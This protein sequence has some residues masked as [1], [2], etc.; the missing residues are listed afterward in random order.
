GIRDFH[1]TGVQTC[2][3]PICGGARAA[4]RVRAAAAVVA[5]FAGNAHHARALHPG[6]QRGAGTAGRAYRAFLRGRRFLVGATVQHHLLDRTGLSAGAGQAA[7]RSTG[8]WWRWWLEQVEVNS[9]R[10]S[11]RSSSFRYLHP[12]PRSFCELASIRSAHDRDRPSDPILPVQQIPGT[13][14]DTAF[15]SPLPALARRR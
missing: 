9:D 14:K 13:A 5:H 15:T 2:A 11:D 1:V 3:L 8:R 4:E 7:E 10:R 6:D 12:R